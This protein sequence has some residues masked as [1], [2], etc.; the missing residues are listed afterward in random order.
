MN[1]QRLL[2][3]NKNGDLRVNWLG[4]AVLSVLVAVSVIAM[5]RKRQ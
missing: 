2:Y 1:D 4:V 3:R 5:I